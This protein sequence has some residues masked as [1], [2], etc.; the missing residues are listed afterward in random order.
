MTN[1]EKENEIGPVTSRDDLDDGKSMDVDAL[2][3]AGELF[4]E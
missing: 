4:L 1:M 2:K 3:L